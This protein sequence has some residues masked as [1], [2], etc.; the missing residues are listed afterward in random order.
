MGRF[1]AAG[2]NGPTQRVN[3]LL[4][5][6]GSPCRWVYRQGTQAQIIT[7]RHTYRDGSPIRVS[8]TRAPGNNLDWVSLFR[9]H[10]KCAGP[11]G[12]T[13]YRYTQTAVVG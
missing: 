1:P 5:W 8:W 9:C 12:Y 13:I 4:R 2:A 6:A 3:P 11:G 10:V 7:N